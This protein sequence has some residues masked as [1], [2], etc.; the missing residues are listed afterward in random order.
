MSARI[1]GFAAAGLV[2]VLAACDFDRSTVLS[3][4]GD[5][6]Y[7]FP[8]VGDGRGLP[9]GTVTIGFDTLFEPDSDLVTRIRLQGLETLASGVYQVWLANVSGGALTDVTPAV[10]TRIVVRTDTT[11]TPEG[12]PLPEPVTVDSTS[13]TST[14]T[15][16]GTAIATTLV[17]SEASLGLDP[18][19]FDIMLVSL[20]PAAGAAAPTT[21]PLWAR[22]V[23]GP[24]DPAELPA[25]L[26]VRFGNFAPDPADEYLFVATGRGTGGIRGNIMIVDDSALARPPVGYYYAAWMVRRDDTG[27]PI[28]TVA[29]GEQTA[30][31]PDRD[32]SLRNADTDDVHPV[33]LDFPM[34]ILAASSRIELSGPNPF[35][36][37]EDVWVTL[38]NKLGDESASAPSIVLSGLVP[39]I[40]SEP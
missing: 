2:L 34:E 19:S 18:Q 25:T 1:A 37:F 3:P 5:P 38:E 21:T 23:V 7:D 35:I 40:V 39:T 14:L 36:G 29:L 24:G 9:R 22:G 32:V 28:D 26:T 17:V 30:P 16:G 6:S 4:L 33:V 10:G 8:L 12:D 15:I 11:F 27:A 31:F 13:G 20:E